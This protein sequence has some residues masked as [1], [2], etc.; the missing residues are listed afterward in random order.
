MRLSGYSHATCITNRNNRAAR[1]SR[2]SDR[3]AVTG[4]REGGSDGGFSR[5]TK[6]GTRVAGRF[7]KVATAGA[8]SI[9]DLGRIRTIPSRGKKFVGLTKLPRGAVVYLDANSIIYAVEKHPDYAPL[10]D[11]LWRPAQTQ[12]IGL[13]SSE[14]SLTV[15]R[16]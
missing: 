13:I 1:P 8:P 3:A 12:T 4:R 5:A 9:Q 7:F 2:G 16:V 6:F 15:V 10:L 11:P 14:L